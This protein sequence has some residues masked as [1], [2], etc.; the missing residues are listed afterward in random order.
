[1]AKIQVRSEK[2]KL[3]YGEELKPGVTYLAS[4][5]HFDEDFRSDDPDYYYESSF[6]R[7]E[8]L[9]ELLPALETY[10]AESCWTILTDHGDGEPD[11]NTISRDGSSTGTTVSRVFTAD[12][13]ILHHRKAPHLSGTNNKPIAIDF[14]KT[15]T[16]C[17]VVELYGEY[18]GETELLRSLRDNVLSK[19]AEGQELIKLYYEWSPTIVKTM[20]EDE[21]FRK[22]VKE[23]IDGVLPLIRG[24]VE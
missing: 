13:M 14:P 16:T 18:S 8:R 5:N 2:V 12:T 11:N 4:T 22:E 15:S 24:V 9:M 21:E 23:M 19:T 10:D 3:T 6:K 1:M 20:Q 17:S 7:Y